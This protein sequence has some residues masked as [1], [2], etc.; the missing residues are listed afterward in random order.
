MESKK[1]VS[2]NEA[3]EL[4]A[5]SLTSRKAGAKILTGEDRQYF[6]THPTEFCEKVL[7]SSLWNTQSNIIEALVGHDRVTARSSHAIGKSFI[8]SE[9]V[10]WFLNCHV[11]STVVTTAPTARQVRDILWREINA[12]YNNSK[13]SLGGRILTQ[14][15]IMNREKW[16]AIGYTT[17][18]HDT[19]KFQGFHN[20]NI[21]VLIDEACFDDKTEILT[22][23][24]WKLFK[25]LV[26]ADTVLTKSLRG[27]KAVY[28]RPNQILELDYTGKMYEIN[29]K[30]CSFA[31][32][33]EHDMF[34]AINGKKEWK[35]MKMSELAN[36][37]EFFLQRH[38]EWSGSNRK[39][40]LLEAARK[41]GKFRKKWKLKEPHRYVPIKPWVQFL[42]WFLSEGSVHP[43]KGNGVGISQ[44][45]S[46]QKRQE[47]A[48]IVRELG[49]EPRI[50]SKG[51]SF[52]S[53][54]IACELRKYG[55]GA[56][57]KFVPSYV[58]ELPSELIEVFLDAYCKGDGYLK[59]A[60]QVFY[61]TS[62]RMSDDLQELILKAGDTAY[63]H[64][65]SNGD[66]NGKQWIVDHQ[67]K[68]S[69][70]YVV[71]RSSVK[72]DIKIRTENLREINYSGKV[73]SV[74]V[75]PF[76]TVFVR[77]NGYVMWSG[78]CG[79][80]DNIY[81]AVEG[82]LSSGK[83]TKLVLIGNPTNEA[84]R[85]GDSFKSTLYKPFHIS[86]FDT[87]NFTQFG[88]T[89]D[90]IKANT[91]K[92]KITEELP[93]P[94]LV[95]PKW[96]SDRYMEWGENN[97]LFQVRV[98]GIF[99]TESIDTLI[100]LYW[101][102]R[103]NSFNFEPSGKKILALDVARTGED[104]IVATIR[105]GAVVYP[106][107]IWFHKDTMETVG[108]M[109]NIIRENSPDI[110]NIDGIGVGGGVVDRL[111]E[112]QN[113]GTLGNVNI[114][115]VNVGMTANQ[116]DR[117]MNVRAEIYW[118]LRESLEKAQIQLPIDSVLSSELCTFK[119]MYTSKGQLKLE[120]KE[121]TKQ[122]LGKSPDRSDSLALTFYDTMPIAVAGD[123]SSIYATKPMPVQ[124]LIEGKMKDGGSKAIYE[125]FK[126]DYNILNECPEC[127]EKAGLSFSND[128][129]NASPQEAKYVWC[130]ICN[131]RWELKR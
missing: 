114:N 100:P 23:A 19:D 36:R 75:P 68:A 10:L 22:R 82:L 93:R 15:L 48:A 127:G 106:Q 52:T 13:Y 59:E 63:I 78:N 21:L 16:F 11:P 99:P 79:V 97:P 8:G 113:S 32:T 103:A 88:I 77:R 45:K 81:E 28:R 29:Q 101:V 94:Y 86:A 112:I 42:G 5:E 131:K 124:G 61:T 31:V 46:E 120:P 122:R 20:E 84:T 14:Q 98:L 64:A 67:A 39:T 109:M 107:I 105:H 85:F 2:L 87:P 47:I 108:R 55:N 70:G 65:R 80:G 128:S 73:Y 50:T 69:Y 121:D 1:S 7:G 9:I 83:K 58:K 37:T 17:E 119:Y 123:L 62:K 66:K 27:G 72:H 43:I 44:Y 117:F 38:F 71:S 40:F 51:I 49:I 74:Q 56:K 115:D 4:L 110:V 33:P 35:L 34:V 102:E 129:G 54:Q 125:R 111:R 130:I 92:E 3:F 6:S 41:R 126:L 25:D 96:V 53:A 104:E 89:L 91:W 116:S 118:K 26:S 12:Q 76:H 24:G 60:T 95:S 18:E 57:N 90:D 30:G